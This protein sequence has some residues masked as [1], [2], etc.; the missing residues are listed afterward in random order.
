MLFLLQVSLPEIVQVTSHS[1][2]CIMSR[3]NFNAG[4]FSSGFFTDIFSSPGNHGCPG[5][6]GVIMSIRHW[7]WFTFWRTLPM[8]AKREKI[9]KAS[10]PWLKES[11]LQD[12]YWG[13]WW[14]TVLL[15]WHNFMTIVEFSFHSLKFLF[16]LDYLSASTFIDPGKYSAV[17][18]IFP[19][20]RY[21]QISLL[22][23]VI[24]IL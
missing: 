18:V 22:I 24:Y 12:M 14:R 2:F 11:I 13:N 8:S 1:E 5:H 15:I 17:I 3:F 19:F 9:W 10:L 7:S 6:A 21:Y 20:K 16:G 23:T 4:S